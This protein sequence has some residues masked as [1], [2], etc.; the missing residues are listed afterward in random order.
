MKILERMALFATCSI[1]PAV[2]LAGAA[3]VR[4]PEL[5]GGLAMLALALVAGV[6]ALIKERR[7]VK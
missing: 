7:R 5:D 6:V 2:A 4:V 1:L 3:A